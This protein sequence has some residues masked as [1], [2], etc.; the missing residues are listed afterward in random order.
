MAAPPAPARRPTARAVPHADAEGERLRHL[1]VVPAR[2]GG[3]R[4]PAPDRP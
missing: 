3:G 1:L 2:P 4:E